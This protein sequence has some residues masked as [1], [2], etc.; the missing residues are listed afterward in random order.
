[1]LTVFYWSQKNKSRRGE[2]IWESNFWNI[3]LVTQKR[4]K[5]FISDIYFRRRRCGICGVQHNIG[6]GLFPRLR[7]SWQYH[8]NFAPSLFPNFQ[9]H[10]NF[11]VY[12]LFYIWVSVH[13]KSIIYK[14]PTRCNFGQYCLLTT[15]RI[16][17]MFR[18]LFASIIRSTKNFTGYTSSR[19]MTRISGCYYRF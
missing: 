18:T 16:L 3:L 19:L 15:A 1:M 13:R 14:E 12:F 11:Q 9:R 6:I 8:S 10:I 5:I 17:C 2:N 7:F 4:E